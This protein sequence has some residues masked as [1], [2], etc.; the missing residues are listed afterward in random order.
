MADE[1]KPLLTT[2]E[3]AKALHVEF[4]RVQYCIRSRKIQPTQI[5][6]Q[7]RLFDSEA[8]SRIR[9]ELCIPTAPEAAA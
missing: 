9:R 1:T 4:H 7:Y 5:A 8:V 6:G 3:I 2:G